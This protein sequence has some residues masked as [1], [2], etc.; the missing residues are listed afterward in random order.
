M[1]ECYKKVALDKNT[2]TG[3]NRKRCQNYLLGEPGKPG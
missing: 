2:V 1:E 3:Y